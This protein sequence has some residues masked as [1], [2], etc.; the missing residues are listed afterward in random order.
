M[1]KKELGGFAKETL[2]KGLLGGLKCKSRGDRQINIEGTESQMSIRAQAHICAYDT[3]ID[4]Q[5]A[6]GPI[7]RHGARYFGQGLARRDT[8]GNGPGPSP[9]RSACRARQWF[10]PVGLARARPDGNRALKPARS[11]AWARLGGGRVSRCKG[12]KPKTLA[13]SAVSR[14]FTAFAFTFTRATP[15][16]LSSRLS[17]TAHRPSVFGRV[18]ST[19]RSPLSTCPPLVLLRLGLG[20][21]DSQYTHSESE[22]SHRTA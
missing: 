6:Y 16:Q 1:Q 9:A 2:S 21:S 14:P 7:V 19:P 4:D 8:S 20:I 10:R 13:A 15:F 5:K 12:P 22:T 3:T 11:T 18:C 17:R